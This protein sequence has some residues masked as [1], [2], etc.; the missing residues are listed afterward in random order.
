M[1]LFDFLTL[2]R[3]YSLQITTPYELIYI[4]QCSNWSGSHPVHKDIKSYPFL[5]S[6][7]PGWSTTTLHRNICNWLHKSFE[8]KCFCDEESNSKYY[9][10]HFKLHIRLNGVWFVKTY[11]LRLKLIQANGQVGIGINQPHPKVLGDVDILSSS[12]YYFV[13]QAWTKFI[14]FHGTASHSR[15]A[16]LTRKLS[17]PIFVFFLHVSEI[18]PIQS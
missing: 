13:C 6:V 7:L 16:L 4:K 10:T 3:Q 12:L 18:C 17:R 14:I 1:T 5:F 11:S 8:S 2:R 15:R 9:W